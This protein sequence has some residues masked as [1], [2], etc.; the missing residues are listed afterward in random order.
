[1]VLCTIKVYEYLVAISG[2]FL[3][4]K[5][6]WILICAREVPEEEI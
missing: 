5:L 1:M 2:Y 6:V 3:Q 4:P